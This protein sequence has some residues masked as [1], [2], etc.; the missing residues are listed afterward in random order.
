M[1]SVGRPD[2]SADVPPPAVGVIGPQDVA[3][4]SAAAF[5]RGADD[6]VAVSLDPLGAPFRTP[7]PALV[8]D[9]AVAAR[10][11]PDEFAPVPVR[12]DGAGLV[13]EVRL[14]VVGEGRARVRG[15]APT[16]VGLAPW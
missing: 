3:A 15:P 9:H 1:A 4:Q 10:S 7:L 16:A 12:W 14:V 5:A 8:V 6:V 2:D 11:Q 13:A